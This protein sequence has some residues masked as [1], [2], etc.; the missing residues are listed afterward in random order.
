MSSVLQHSLDRQ[1]QEHH[2]NPYL[3]FTD[4]QSTDHDHQSRLF[5]KG[6]DKTS[7]WIASLVK[8]EQTEALLIQQDK[9]QDDLASQ[10]FAYD[11]PCAN[12]SLDFGE[13]HFADLISY[14]D[15]PA[16]SPVN[17]IVGPVAANT[18]APFPETRGSPAST[19]GS[20]VS[21]ASLHTPRSSLCQSFQAAEQAFNVPLFDATSTDD[22]VKKA[23]SPTAKK[24][25][26]DITS[27]A[28]MLDRSFSE[29]VP[30]MT[31][32]KDGSATFVNGLDYQDP[33]PSMAAAPQHHYTAN[34]SFVTM[35]LPGEARAQTYHQQ[36]PFTGPQFVNPFS[37]KVQ[38]SVEM[39]P[40]LY[41]NQAMY[42]LAAPFQGASQ[43][44]A[45]P[46]EGIKQVYHPPAVVNGSMPM[47]SDMGALSA[48]PCVPVPQM[49][50]P[51]SQ[52]QSPMSIHAQPNHG[53]SL[54]HY[55]KNMA[56]NMSSMMMMTAASGHNL[57]NDF[58]STIMSHSNAPSEIE[59]AVDAEVEAA[60]GDVPQ[61]SRKPLHLRHS[62]SAV[63]STRGKTPYSVDPSKR[64]K[65]ASSLIVTSSD[66][67]ALST[68]ATP[69]VVSKDLYKEG[70]TKVRNPLGGGRGYI[71]GETPDDP[72]KKHKCDIC[73]RGFARLYNLKVSFIGSCFDDL[74]GC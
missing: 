23:I 65:S 42:G 11:S 21:T 22:L 53:L 47:Y 62:T 52:E 8:A 69:A 19:T 35:N 18:F 40:G 31:Q 38:P 70:R 51:M 45:G 44:V 28:S 33:A 7:A 4:Q 55:H 60:L 50:A 17:P 34:A 57:K 43:P 15:S 9:Q 26:T 41:A 48:A 59:D 66:P 74:P 12:T 64:H 61:E 58:A 10:L 1:Q 56:S 68:A 39:Q 37:S 63:S 36:V 2:S 67:V 20:S 27:Y 32:S 71:P 29:G 72:K 14:G 73:G 16:H 54:D 25:W 49:M 46:F 24:D 6:L 5:E 30:V 3:V 13:D